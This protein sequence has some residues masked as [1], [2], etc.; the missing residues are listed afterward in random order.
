MCIRDSMYLYPY[1]SVIKIEDNKLD[2]YK[3]QSHS[4]CRNYAVIVRRERDRQTDVSPSWVMNSDCRY[5][6]SKA[7][8]HCK[9]RAQPYTLPFTYTAEQRS[10]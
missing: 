3:R 1:I 6:Q 7:T 10:L 2:V 9:L 8:S 5:R 4:R